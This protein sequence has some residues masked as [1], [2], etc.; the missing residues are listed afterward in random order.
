MGSDW[1][2][3]PSADDEETLEDWA[4]SPEQPP[5]QLVLD[6]MHERGSEARRG[7]GY[8]WAD[9]YFDAE[10]LDLMLEDEAAGLQPAASRDVTDQRRRMTMPND[11][12]WDSWSKRIINEVDDATWLADPKAAVEMALARAGEEIANHARGIAYVDAANLSATSTAASQ[13]DQEFGRSHPDLVGTDMER[14]AVAVAIG[15]VK[16]DPRFQAGI[17]NPRTR[18][19]AFEV[20]AL[21]ASQELGRGRAGA[22]RPSDVAAESLERSGDRQGAAMWEIINHTRATNRGL[23]G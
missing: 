23:G 19:K 18:E 17:R 5:E 8:T 15:K 2:D 16:D 10:Q 12:G 9:R 13:L 20:V 3:F 21:L 14:Y 1:S 11:N 6:E 4:L 7:S 22:R